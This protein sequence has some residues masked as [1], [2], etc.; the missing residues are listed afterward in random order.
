MRAAKGDKDRVVMLPERL[1]EP[2]RQRLDRV[3]DLAALRAELE[4]IAADL[5]VEIGLSELTDSTAAG[6]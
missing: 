3:R 6:A 1:R 4:R 5:L 2:L